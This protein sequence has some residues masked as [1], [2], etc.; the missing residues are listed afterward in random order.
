MASCTWDS[1]DASNLL[2]PSYG[3]WLLENGTRVPAFLTGMSVSYI[4]ALDRVI[5]LEWLVSLTN[6]TSPWKQSA[7]IHTSR[8]SLSIRGLEQLIE[9]NGQYFI[10]SLD[11]NGTRHGVIVNLQNQSHFIFQ[12][13]YHLSTRLFLFFSGNTSS[14]SQLVVIQRSAFNLL[15]YKEMNGQT[16]HKNE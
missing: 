13:I 5:E 15:Q 7:D 12:I 9:P 8:R 3:A 10:K 11:P 16:L 4:A 2:A 14:I 6:P 1:G